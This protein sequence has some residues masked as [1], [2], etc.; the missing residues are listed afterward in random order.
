MVDS[1]PGLIVWFSIV[2]YVCGEAM[3]KNSHFEN[4]RMETAAADVFFRD[5]PFVFW[6][7]NVAAVVGVQ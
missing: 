3:N 5:F 7:Q 2:I 1:I 4:A 6:R